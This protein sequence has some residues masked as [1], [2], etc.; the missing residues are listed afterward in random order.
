MWLKASNKELQLFL[1][2]A[3]TYWEKN[4]PQPSTDAVVLVEA[5]HQDIRVNLRNLAIANAIRKLQPARLVVFTGVEEHWHQTLWTEFDVS[6]MTRLAQAYGASEVIDVWDA[7][8]RGA[9]GMPQMDDKT[10]LAYT[11]ATYCRLA[12]VPSLPADHQSRP[13][14]QR[15]RRYAAGLAAVYEQMFAAQPVVALVTSH[16]DYDQWGLATEVARNCGVP[17]VHSQQTGCLKAY[18]LFPAKDTHTETFRGELT[19]QIGEV[20]ESQ[21][22]A[23]REDLKATAELVAWRAKVNLG[24]PSWWRGGVT[25]SVD[26]SNPADRARLRTHAA[27]RFGLDPGKP[28][29]AVFNHAVSDAL[30]TNR[31]LFPDLADWFAQTADFAARHREA[32][33]LFL[34]HPSQVLYDSTGFFDSVARAHRDD[35]HLVFRPSAT[36]SKNALW[37]L[38][39]LGV[40]VR[41]SVSNELPAYGI[42]VV[43]AGWSE[44]SS[45]G[46]STVAESADEYW[47]I[48]ER[49][50]AAIAEGTD[51]VSEEQVRRARLWLWLYRSGTDVVTPQV[52]Q[53]EVWPAGILLKAMRAT[54]RHIES[55]ADP[56]FA[57]VERM[58]QRQEPMLTRTDMRTDHIGQ[59][60]G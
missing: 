6:K 25:A 31:E 9:H 51:L 47:A 36:L 45:C 17:V 18:A 15:R 11:D 23:H 29:I 57:T 30:G 44:W 5:F 56:L 16:V 48:L 28:I 21:V 3:H 46:L 52:P 10:L 58:W 12:K 13:D 32:Q 14:Y 43:Q 60:Q 54:F 33:W 40:T 24:R 38:T 7:V 39:D 59:G 26:L 50:I 22:W 37:S 19:K 41:G 42:P 4:L 27:A 35:K 53:W 8:R 34:D 2:A 49:H 20:F 1:E 55:D